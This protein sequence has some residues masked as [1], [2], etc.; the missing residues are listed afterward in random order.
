MFYVDTRKSEYS[1][2]SPWQSNSNECPQYMFW[3]K[4]YLLNTPS[5]F[6]GDWIHLVDFQ[7]FS[8]GRQLLGL[9]T[10]TPSENGFALKEKHL[11]P[12][13]ANSFLLEYTLFLKGGKKN[14]ERITSPESVVSPLI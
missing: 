7:P 2:E 1:L 5:V 11:L 4:N 13:G 14:S 9:P 3:C 12:W 8:Q 10:Q 6:L